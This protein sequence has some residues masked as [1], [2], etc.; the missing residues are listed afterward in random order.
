MI[1][2]GTP[3]D[4]SKYV[5]LDGQYALMAHQA[6]NCPEWKDDDGSLWFKR[7]KKLLKIRDENDI[8]I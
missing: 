7:T 4:T 6:G 5:C 3:S 8:K 1:R 2:L